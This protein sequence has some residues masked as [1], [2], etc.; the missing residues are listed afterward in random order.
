M[1]FNN[2]AGTWD[3][4]GG[5]DYAITIAGNT[6]ATG[7]AVAA[8][9]CP[10]HGQATTITYYGTLA[11]SASSITLHWG[12]NGWNG[13]TDTPMVKQPNG[14]WRATIT[15]PTGATS[16]NTAFYN[17]S[18]TWDSNGGSNYNLTVS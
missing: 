17:Q 14:S 5:S 13:T 4:N 11:A 1:A 15:M 18:N 3:N 6:C 12:Y 8:T 16:L 2:G 10:V 7:N 9:G